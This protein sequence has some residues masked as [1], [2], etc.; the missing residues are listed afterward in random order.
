MGLWRPCP[1]WVADPGQGDRP[2]VTLD[3]EGALGH[4][5]FDAVQ[6]TE[7]LARGSGGDLDAIDVAAVEGVHGLAQL[8]HD[9]IGQVNQHVDRAQAHVGEPNLHPQRR[10]L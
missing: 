8:A 7:L 3:H 2:A 1:P 10:G 9:V 6:G 4:G 5:P